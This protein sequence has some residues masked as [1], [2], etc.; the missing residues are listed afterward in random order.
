MSLF[1]EATPNLS[2]VVQVIMNPSIGIG[3]TMN[4]RS[5]SWLNQPSLTIFETMGTF[6]F[7][8]YDNSGNTQFFYASLT[9]GTVLFNYLCPTA[10]TNMLLTLTQNYDYT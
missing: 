8:I 2:A 1:S 4:F 3:W 7:L 5:A 9:L 10:K 6:A